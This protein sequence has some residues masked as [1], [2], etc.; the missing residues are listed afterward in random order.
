MTYFYYILFALCAYMELSEKI[1][2][3]NI[4]NKI[5]L[6][7]VMVGASISIY[8]EAPNNL[9]AI[10]VFLHFICDLLRYSKIKNRRI[11]DSVK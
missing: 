4:L 9:I 6:G 8:K 5:G 2:T 11:G 10:G 3:D 7:C 1:N